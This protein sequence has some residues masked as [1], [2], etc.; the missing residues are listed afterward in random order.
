MLRTRKLRRAIL[1]RRRN[2]F[3]A[4]WRTSKTIRRGI[5]L[6]IEYPTRMVEGTFRKIVILL[7]PRLFAG[8]WIEPLVAA[9]RTEMLTDFR[10]WQANENLSMYLQYTLDAVW[11]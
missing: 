11:V 2:T 8:I 3:G 7:L 4:Y 10:N 6:N 1:K 9:H 5:T